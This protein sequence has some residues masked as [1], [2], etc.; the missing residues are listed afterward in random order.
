MTGRRILSTAALATLLFGLMTPPAHAQFTPRFSTTKRKAEGQMHL[1]IGSTALNLGD[2]TS[3]PWPELKAGIPILHARL[4]IAVPVKE[5]ALFILLEI[6]GNTGST[7]GKFVSVS[8][9]EYSVPTVGQRGFSFMAGLMRSLNERKTLFGGG[10]GF[11]LIEHD[12][13]LPPSMLNAG[14]QFL[15]DPFVHIGMGLNAHVAK[16]VGKLKEDTLIMLEGRYKVAYM[17]GNV[18]GS[19]GRKILMSEFQITA[20]LAVK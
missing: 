8:Q 13:Q 2:Y 15:R 11:H 3:Q 18:P 10:I 6:E 19:E 9:I 1:G 16:A 20:Y 4:G 5:D 17:G 14:A 7:E 12:P